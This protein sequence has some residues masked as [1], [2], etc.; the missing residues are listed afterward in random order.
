MGNVESNNI[1]NQKFEN[2]LDNDLSLIFFDL[3]INQTENINIGG[4]KDDVLTI[5]RYMNNTKYNFLKSINSIDNNEYLFQQQSFNNPKFNL[6]SFYINNGAFNTAIPITLVNPNNHLLYGQKLVLK[7]LLVNKYENEVIRTDTS[8]VEWNQRHYSHYCKDKKLFKNLLLDIYFYGDNIY[9]Y[10]DQNTDNTS[11]IQNNQE[12]ITKYINIL[13][14]HKFSFNISKYYDD[15]FSLNKTQQKIFFIKVIS[16]LYFLT[17]N[18]FMI[19]DFKIENVRTDNNI[20]VVCIDYDHHNRTFFK[21]RKENQYYIKNLTYGANI[22][23]FLKKEIFY[24]FKDGISEIEKLVIYRKNNIDKNI[25]KNYKLLNRDIVY[26]NN[27]QISENDINGYK[28]N[29]STLIFFNKCLNIDGI[30]EIYFNSS[31]KFTDNINAIENMLVQAYTKYKLNKTKTEYNIGLDKVNSTGLV[32]IILSLFFAPIFCDNNEI[33]KYDAFV[34]CEIINT[35]NNKTMTMEN[36]NSKHLQ[37]ISRY[38]SFKNLNNISIINNF[39]NNFIQPLNEELTDFCNYLKLL[40]FDYESET[41]LLAP[42]YDDIPRYEYVFE[43]IKNYFL[44]NNNLLNNYT[45]DN[46]ELLYETLLKENIS[47]TPPEGTDYSFDLKSTYNVWRGQRLINKQQ[48]IKEKLNFTTIRPFNTKFHL[49]YDINNIPREF[50]ETN[51]TNETIKTNETNETKESN[52][53]IITN[54]KG[55][56]KK[57]ILKKL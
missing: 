7:I 14:T 15:I 52:E 43:Y 38:S 45:T 49:Y 17:K 6:N 19:G 51:E 44:L 35:T 3:V 8:Y 37:F 41:G 46:M 25:F 11:D 29:F 10:I 47:E 34:Y 54:A 16:V 22:P 50:I 18:N 13:E 26:D 57:Y 1:I 21:Y 28:L 30:K 31:Y 55:G 56:N 5:L 33:I 12:K 2:C 40:L 36:T 39:V 42:E 24:L 32:D 9:K 27:N 53:N 23:C 48:A 4:G 20:N